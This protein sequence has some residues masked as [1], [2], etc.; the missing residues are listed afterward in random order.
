MVNA[1]RAI[2]MLCVIGAITTGASCFDFGS[3]S[4][5]Q[6]QSAQ[7][8]SNEDIFRTVLRE[9]QPVINECRLRRLRGELPTF[10]ASA[11]CSNRG[12]IAAFSAARYKYIDLIEYLAAKRLE[13]A[14]QIDRKE[15]TEDQARRESVKIML[16]IVTAVQERDSRAR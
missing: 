2:K 9:A 1:M 12:L 15:V 3:L 10:A 7:P 8:T 13:V 5:A 6:A 4:A 14:G 11:E 16:H